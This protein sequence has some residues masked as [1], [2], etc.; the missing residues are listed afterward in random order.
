[1]RE[2]ELA[3]VCSGGTS[4]TWDLAGDAGSAWREEEMTGGKHQNHRP[5]AASA[6]ADPDGVGDAV[7]EAIDNLSERRGA[8]REA[9]LR[10]IAEA[11]RRYSPVVE[12]VLERFEETLCDHLMAALKRGGQEGALAS[13]V[14]AILFLFGSTPGAL[15][16]RA[17]PKLKLVAA[18]QPTKKGRR[19]DESIA[20]LTTLAVGCL[21][22]AEEDSG[23]DVDAALD[24]LA[25]VVEGEA[26]DLVMPDEVRTAALDAWGL[27]ATC[28]SSAARLQRSERV[29]PFL[30]H[31]LETLPGGGTDSLEL[32]SMCGET[33][34]LVYEALLESQSDAVESVAE[35]ASGD[36]ETWD[37]VREMFKERS[38][39][40]SKKMSKQAK[41]EQHTLFRQLLGFMNDGDL[42]ETRVCFGEGRQL[43]VT[44]WAGKKRLRSL[45][46][47][48]QGG[49]PTHLAENPCMSQIFAEF[50]D[51]FG[52][53]AAQGDRDDYFGGSKQ[54]TVMRDRDR[55]MR[56]REKDSFFHSENV[57]QDDY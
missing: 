29:L 53:D 48:L 42:P 26:E 28:L 45:R 15:Y 46:T 39:E 1:M 22:H 55:A 19:C 27:V 2:D 34:A 52:E 24:F 12:A 50:W 10:S 17:A 9:A 7:A 20:A 11:L 37:R 21:T 38:R 30:L 8:T 6:L 5:Q 40:S 31:S 36:E 54:H 32:L 44:T 18:R 25:D 16:R 41:K 57:A 4:D 23:E 49:L 47:C 51:E 56:Q 33:A 13:H 43:D 14:L 35:V 3:S